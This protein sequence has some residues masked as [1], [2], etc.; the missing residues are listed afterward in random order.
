MQEAREQIAALEEESHLALD[1]VR[2]ALRGCQ[3]ERLIETQKMQLD[4]D[5]AAAVKQ[6]E[7]V[8][9]GARLEACREALHRAT[10]AIEAKEV[11]AATSA[12]AATEETEARAV[13]DRLGSPDEHA[14][15]EQNRWVVVGW[16]HAF[17]MS[18]T[19]SIRRISCFVDTCRGGKG[20]AAGEEREGGKK[21]GRM[22]ERGRGGGRRRGERRRR[23]RR[24]RRKA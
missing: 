15:F 20:R 12:T 18:C 16:L 11:T 21:G 6:R 5:A 4:M 13:R 19:H 14:L 7:L 8:D 1:R 23:R 24:R 3:R 22:R 2:A 17:K 9:M 10:A